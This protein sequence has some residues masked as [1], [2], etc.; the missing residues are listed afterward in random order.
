ME[1]VINDTTNLIFDVKEQLGD[2]VYVKLMDN[3]KALHGMRGRNVGSKRKKYPRTIPLILKA[4]INSE[5]GGTA[6]GSFTTQGGTLYSYNVTIG[7]TRHDDVKCV[8]D[9]TANGLGFISTTTSCHV[10]KARNYCDNNGIMMIR[11]DG[12]S[13]LEP[14]QIHNIS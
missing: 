13:E 2:G 11:I 4:W 6:N 14:L 7:Y 8:V 9:H 3:M 1:A 12:S 10:G 5:E